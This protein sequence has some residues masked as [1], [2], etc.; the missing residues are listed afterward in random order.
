MCQQVLAPIKED[1]FPLLS[2]YRKRCE[3][4]I[5]HLKKLNEEGS[6]RVADFFKIVNFE[7]PSQE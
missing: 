1:K 4:N 3:S 5:P 6:Q 7:L 2:E